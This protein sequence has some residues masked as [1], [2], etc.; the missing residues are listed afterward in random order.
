MAKILEVRNVSKKY[1]NKDGEI[2]ALQNV[3][4]TVKKGEFVSVIGP[5]GCGKSTLLS[6][7]AGL[8]EKNTGEIY[9]EGEKI[10]KFLRPDDHIIALCIE[11]KQISKEELKKTLNRMQ[12]QSS[13]RMVFL[14]GGSLGLWDKLIKK[15]ELKL[16]FSKMTFPHQLM[17]VMLTEVICQL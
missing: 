12:E 1:Q 6:I 8:E 7:I 2:L 9:I 4:M 10:E 16:S 14:I 3:N 13:G 17:R 11:G 5:S 15:A